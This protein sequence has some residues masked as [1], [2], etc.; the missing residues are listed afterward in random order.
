MYEDYGNQAI[1]VN[2][3]LLRWIKNETSVYQFFATFGKEYDVTGKTS[4]RSTNPKKFK[5]SIFSSSKNN[6]YTE[7]DFGS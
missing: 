7:A 4:L 2:W 6:L 1:A 5:V 3:K